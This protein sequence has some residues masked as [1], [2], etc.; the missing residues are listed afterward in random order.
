MTF[1]YLS[2]GR[3]GAMMEVSLVNEGPVTLTIDSKNPETS[4]SNGGKKEAAAAATGDD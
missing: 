1:L 2:D 4:K 3:F